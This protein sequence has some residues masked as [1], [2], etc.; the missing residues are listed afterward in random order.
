MDIFPIN[1]FPMDRPSILGGKTNVGDVSGVIVPGVVRGDVTVNQFLDGSRPARELS[2]PWDEMQDASEVFTLLRWRTAVSAFAGR[3]AEIHALY[4]WATAGPEVSAKFLTG[5][6][7]MGKSRL[8]AELAKRLR[9]DNWAAGFADLRKPDGY[10]ARRP[11]TLLLIDY[12]EENREAV[13]TLLQDFSGLEDAGRLR[14]LFLSRRPYDDWRELVHDSGAAGRFDPTSVELAPLAGEG[15]Y[16]VF[17]SAQER[18]AETLNTVPLSLSE[19][20]FLAWLE[21]A[22]ENARPLFIVAT[23][24]YSAID[25]QEPAVRFIGREVISALVERE[26]T[27]LRRISE[28]SGLDREALGRL[29]AAAAIRGTVDRETLGT[30]ASAEL[31]MRVPDDLDRIEDRGPSGIVMDGAIPAPTPDIVAAALVVEVFGREPDLAP[32]WLWQAMGEDLA[33]GLERLGRLSHDA[34]IVLALHDHRLSEWLARAVAGKPDRCRLVAPVVSMDHLPG[35]LIP[36]GAAVWRTLADVAEDEAGRAQSL[37]N[38]SVALADMGDAPGA[39]AA[40]RDAVVIRR[41]LAASSPARY[42]PDLGR[43]LSVLSDQLEKAEDNDAALD[44]TE[45]AIR[46]IRPYAERFPGTRS[47]RLL[48]VMQSDLA[49]LKGGDGR[50]GSDQT[51]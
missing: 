4:A 44:A 8:A 25:P 51:K 43:S 7:G 50:T 47:A 34:E 27:R 26:L 12:P 6:G 11:G 46:L 17:C 24:I 1:L 36:L 29:L 35:G 37:N 41:R 42:E 33:G 49:R 32:E 28:G 14:L 15:A 20:A 9:E 39:L 40:I 21:L 18:A 23:A 30:L 19:E 13:R 5:E 10:F 16:R 38:L 45:E 48:E 31:G 3:E 22:P 2:I